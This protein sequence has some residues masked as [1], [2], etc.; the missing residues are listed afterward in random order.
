[1]QLDDAAEGGDYVW[2]GVRVRKVDATDVTFP[3][4]G[5]TPVV[6]WYRG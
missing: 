1:M 6:T 4:A 5:A 3:A 2:S